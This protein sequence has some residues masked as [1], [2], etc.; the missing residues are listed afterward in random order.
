MPGTPPI[1]GFPP[2]PPFVPPRTPW[3]R[4]TWAHVGCVLAVPALGL[5]NEFL[6]FLMLLVALFLLWWG[7][8]WRK[9]WKVTATV[10]AVL[11]FGMVL[12]PAPQDGT[13]HTATGVDGKARNAGGLGGSPSPSGSV[14]GG[15]APRP[16]PDPEITDYRGLRLDTARERAQAAGFAVGDHNASDQNDSIWMRSNWTVCFQQVGI[17]AAGTRTVDFGAVRTGTPCPGRDGGPIPW[18]KMPNLI[19]ATWKVAQ[20]KL[21][22]LDIRSDR[23]YAETVYENDALPDEGEY[24]EWKVCAHDP[25]PRERVPAG[26]SVT[27]WLSAPDNHCPART[28]KDNG[29]ALL[30]DRDDDGDPDYL[31]PF[32]HDRNRNSTFPDGLTDGSGGSGN[33]GGSSSSSSGGGGWGGC[34]S[35]WC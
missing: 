20:K 9:S 13:S 21:A 23:T 1:P 8:A 7:N 12:P 26:T 32:P 19:G 17:S 35:R 28:G 22:T 11:L 29:S 10:A 27:L 31:D 18:P 33:S 6:G 5:L 14:V 34:R 2:S 3:W 15:K 30:P 16:T 4:T 25:V 24:D